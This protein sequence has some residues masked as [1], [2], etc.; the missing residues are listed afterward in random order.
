[1]PGRELAPITSPTT[2]RLASPIKLFLYMWER[3]A[4][5]WIDVPES[6]FSMVAAFRF[7]YTLMELL[8][9]LFL[10][11]GNICKGFSRDIMLSA[12]TITHATALKLPPLSA[13]VS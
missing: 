1:M 8:E 5:S 4:R 3:S 11:T 10:Q 13:H 9:S 2:S 7:L 6:G 12:S